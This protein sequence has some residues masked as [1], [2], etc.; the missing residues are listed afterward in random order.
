MTAS[1]LTKQDEATL[2]AL[3]QLGGSR[4]QEDSLVYTGD[5]FVLPA[6][7]ESRPM[8]KVVDFLQAYDE[9][10]NQSFNIQRQF[11][12]H[13]YDVA[14]SFQVA[15]KKIFG[16]TGFGKESMSFF[17]PQPPEY[18]TVKISSN[19][20]I[21]VPWELV[22]L[23][24]IGATF[25]IGHR[26]NRAG[27][28]IGS[29][30]VTLPKKF[31]GHV[32]GV[33][34]A[35]E[36]ELTTASIYRGKAIDADWMN[37]S[38]LDLSSVHPDRVIYNEDVERQLEANIWSVLRHSE[39]IVG[40][41]MGLKRAVLLEGPYGTGK[42]L[43][44]ALTAREAVQNGWT[45]INVRPDQDVHLA[46]ESARL[47]APAVVFYEDLDTIAKPGSDDMISKLLD[48]FDGIS[49]KSNP[50]LAVLTTNHVETLHKGM[51]RPGRLDAVIHIG[52]HDH[53]AIIRLAKVLLPIAQ[54][55]KDVDWD[56]V[57][58]SMDGYLPAFIK[59]AVDRALRYA[60]ART[61]SDDE[62]LITTEDLTDAADGLRPQWELM[63]GAGEKKDQPALE[64]VFGNM[65]DEA[66][67]GSVEDRLDG[68]NL[69]D[70][71]G[72]R[73]FVLRTT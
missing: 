70:N 27:L 6:Q 17:G 11:D 38:F 2:N 21:Q 61:N 36:H 56:A 54:V 14:N 9:E 64:R 19:E 69:F 45:F 71:D 12:Y 13:P 59:E 31:R 28:P 66:V 63:T 3:I 35:I 49:S 32:E 20:T 50:V 15:L 34:K 33:F 24:I 46:L 25:H 23:P 65:I 62:I 47:L 57:A 72:D 48:T 26:P 1:K 53:S 43:T 42:T 41:G 5:K 58:K 16:T 51:L 39:R 4:Q 10:M 55:D 40:L 18:K 30:A 67:D 29:I 22:E 68:A 8:S 37:P 52:Q 73:Q 60:V 7:Y 44:G